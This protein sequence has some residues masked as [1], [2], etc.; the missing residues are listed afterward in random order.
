VVAPVAAEVDAPDVVVTD[1]EVAIPVA[2]EAGEEEDE[3]IPE[4][5]DEEDVIIVEFEVPFPFA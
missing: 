5:E 2:D 4:A 3:D 1:P